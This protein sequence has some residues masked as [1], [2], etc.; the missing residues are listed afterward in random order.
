L[1]LGTG[2]ALGL[3]ASLIAVVVPVILVILGGLLIVSTLGSIASALTGGRTGLSGFPSASGLFISFIILEIIYFVGII[4]FLIAMH[5]LSEYYK[6]SDIFRNALWGFLAN[7]IGGVVLVVIL[8]ALIFSM[9]SALSSST[10]LSGSGANF[11]VFF[12]VVVLGIFVV[13]I[14]SAVLYRRAFNKLGDKSGVSSFKTAGTLYLIGT[15]L[16]IL[17]VGQL[18]VWIG[19]IFAVSG[20][21]LL[22]QQPGGSSTISYPASQPLETTSTQPSAAVG[23]QKLKSC[24]HCGAEISADSVYCPNCGKQVQ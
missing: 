15:A 14:V 22:K 18:I 11:L 4:L 5:S 10:G 13:S 6:E 2:K 1:S 12:I 9:I 19:W 24:V 20:F 7:I 23:S 16:T 3:A 21:S 8:I 17:L